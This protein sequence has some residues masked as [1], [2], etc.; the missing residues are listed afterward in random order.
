MT[1][2]SFAAILFALFLLMMT[3]TAEGC[4]PQPLVTYTGSQVALGQ[5]GTHHVTGELDGTPLPPM[6]T[7]PAACRPPGE[8]RSWPSP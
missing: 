6:P 5:T 3:M 1:P 7:M 8:W 4:D 2:A